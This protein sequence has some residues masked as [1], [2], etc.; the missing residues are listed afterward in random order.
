MLAFLGLAFPFPALRRTRHDI[1]G[2]IIQQEEGIMSFSSGDS[3][4]P[5]EGP[6]LAR[7]AMAMAGQ[8]GLLTR[9]LSG[10]SWPS[11]A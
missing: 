1:S 8:L 11:S 10:R 5:F 9:T 7:G 4:R 2:P 3:V 6:Q